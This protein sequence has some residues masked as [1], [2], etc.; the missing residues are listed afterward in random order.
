[1]QL[2]LLH[3]YPDLVGKRSIFCGYGSGPAS[4]V[5]TG[6]AVTTGQYGYYIDA[7][8]EAT[9]VSGSY[10]VTFQPSG[11]GPRATWKAIW[12]GVAGHVAS[13]AIAS[14][15]SGQTPGTYS[16]AATGGGG[17]GAV[18]SI[19]VAGGGTVTAVP[20]ITSSGQGYTSAPTFTLVSGGTPATFT[21]TLTTAGPVATDTN[22]SGETVQVGG[23]G[24]TY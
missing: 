5:Q 24:G 1:M 3:G 22:L 2:T 9:T 7:I 4:Y 19:V 15:G 11:F 14:A 12:N 16:V 8:F 10:A 13:L 21:A 23:F 18:A 20:T 6:D 17:T